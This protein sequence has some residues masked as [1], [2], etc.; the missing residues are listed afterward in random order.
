M[1]ARIAG[2]G[3]CD[4]I[5][6]KELDTLRDAVVIAAIS[7]AQNPN[8]PACELLRGAV[9]KYKTAVLR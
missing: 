8:G 6:L 4:E 7:W 5:R 9:D 3:S 1:K 2:S